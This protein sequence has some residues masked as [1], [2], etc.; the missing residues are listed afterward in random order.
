M[1]LTQKTNMGIQASDENGIRHAILEELNI[2][3]DEAKFML[4]TCSALVNFIISKA[5]KNG[6]L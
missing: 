5:A 6:L 3:F 1:V 2:G 4:I